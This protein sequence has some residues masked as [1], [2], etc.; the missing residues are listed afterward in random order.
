MR[1]LKVTNLIKGREKYFA[2]V[3]NEQG[4]E[5]DV[6]YDPNKETYSCCCLHGSW[7]RWAPRFRNIIC[8]HAKQL[9]IE[10]EKDEL[11]GE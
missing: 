1:E 11:N 2:I 10:I 6:W 8:C 4:K 3:E 5:Y 7:Y 9:I